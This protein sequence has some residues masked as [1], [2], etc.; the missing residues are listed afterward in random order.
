MDENGL[1]AF[2]FATPFKQADAFLHRSFHTAMRDEREDDEAAKPS[3]LSDREYLQ[4]SAN[5]LEA[6]VGWNIR[7]LDN[8]AHMAQ[9]ALKHSLSGPAEIRSFMEMMRRMRRQREMNDDRHVC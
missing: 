9:A 4:S 3:F 6:S 1:N 2:A 7:D 8:S 5:E